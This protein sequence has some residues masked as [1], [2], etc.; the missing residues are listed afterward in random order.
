MKVQKRVLQ[1][2][3]GLRWLFNVNLIGVAL[4]AT[5]EMSRSVLAY[6][7]FKRGRDSQS[8]WKR[9]R[10]ELCS[11]GCCRY[12]GSSCTRTSQVLLQVPDVALSRCKAYLQT[13]TKASR[14][15]KN[16]TNIKG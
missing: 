6:L 16:Q 10:C 11:S 1:S 9:N 15:L 13:P 4:A 12:S 5:S 3:G 8:G 7:R 14:P 2:P